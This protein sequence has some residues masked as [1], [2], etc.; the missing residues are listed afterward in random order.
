VTALRSAPFELGRLPRIAFGEGTRNRLAGLAAGYGSR[1]LLVTGARSLRGTV[2]G[3]ALLASFAGHGLDV[4]TLAIA[5]EPSPEFV[6][7]AVRD[8]RPRG[9]EVVV[10]IGGGSALD[11]AKAL[12]ALLPGGR[13]VMDHLEEVGGGVPYEG[14]ALPCIAAPTTA[15]T[16]SEATRNAVLSRIGTDGFK[17]SFR[18]E[19][20]VPQWAVVDPELLATCPPPLIACDGLDALT[21]LIESYVSLRAGPFTDALA[22]Q[23]LGAV[24]DGLLAWYEGTGEPRAARSSMAYAALL[25]GLTLAN[26][27]LGVVH[28]LSAPLGAGFPIPHGVACGTLL[29]AA[30]AANVQALIARDPEGQALTR[31]A[32]AWEILSGAT[33]LPP[34]HQASVRLTAL[35]ADWVERL[36]APRLGHYGVRDADVARLVAEGRAGSTKTNPIALTDAETAAVLRARL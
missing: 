9:I 5:S 35:L 7:G 21:Q 10:G 36:E 22:E 17:R 20:L 8:L 1:V 18:H 30:T 29:A 14:P 3:R 24:R 11:T 16:G 4:A 23:G 27:G 6:D 28:G 31:Y 15:G 32:R 12:A 33:V 2:H 13:P 26:A 34:P 25:S 19:E